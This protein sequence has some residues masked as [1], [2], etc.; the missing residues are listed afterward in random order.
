MK[1]RTWLRITSDGQVNALKQQPYRENGMVII[2]VDLD[3][4]DE[5]FQPPKMPVV[6]I[7]LDAAALPKLSVVQDAMESLQRA[8]IRVKI[9]EAE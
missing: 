4:P 2:P 8:G 9:V 3:I 6:E 5:A 7:T 1:I